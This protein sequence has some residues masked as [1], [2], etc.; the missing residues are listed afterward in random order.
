MCCCLLNFERTSEDPIKR[1][2]QRVLLEMLHSCTPNSNKENILQSFQMED[3]CIRVLVATIAFGMGVDCKKVNRTI[4]FGPA[5]NVEAFM[6]ESGRA[7]RD[8][9]QSTA[10]MLYQSFQLAHVEKDMKTYINS[11]DCRQTFLLSFFDVTFCPIAP[12]HLCCDN[13][14]LICNCGLQDCKVLSYPAA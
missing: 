8:G 1:N 13:C 5:K 6:Q 11:K 3:G 14:S 2:P 9:T 7:G 10:Y 12:L 4:H